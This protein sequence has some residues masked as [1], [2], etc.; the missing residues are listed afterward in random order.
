MFLPYL[1]CLPVFSMQAQVIYRNLI[2]F[3]Q[4]SVFIS[5]RN[6]AD[7]FFLYSLTLLS[8]PT[9]QPISLVSLSCPSLSL[10]VLPPLMTS[11]SGLLEG[12][13]QCP[14]VVVPTSHLSVKQQD[15]Q[16]END[17]SQSAG[18]KRGGGRRCREPRLFQ[19][20]KNKQKKKAKH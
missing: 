8:A 19:S 1:N 2:G 15:T 9:P 7:V 13:S 6:P 3:N 14:L 5:Q 20:Y 4:K 18:L 12:A 10:Q 17:N 16:K 11:P